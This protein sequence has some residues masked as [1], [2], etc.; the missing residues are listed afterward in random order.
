MIDAGARREESGRRRGALFPVMKKVI[1]IIFVAILVA[2][3]RSSYDVTLT[4]GMQFTGVTKPKLEREKG[5][6][7]FN[8]A[9]G[10]NFAIPETRIRTIE[11]HVRVKESQFRN[12]SDTK[13]FNS[14]GR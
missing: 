6:Y 13:N 9:A 5:V 3:C 2:G 8:N 7:V 11:P 14:S 1:A 4:N 10:K 12:Q